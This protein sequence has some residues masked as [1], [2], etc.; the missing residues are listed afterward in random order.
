M[1]P[2]RN[3]AGIWLTAA[4]LIQ[5]AAFYAI[6]SR[7]EVTPRFAPLDA[8]PAAFGQWTLLR[9]NPVTSDVQAILRADDTMDRLYKNPAGEPADLF[10]AYFK[11]QRTGA[12]PHS[13]KNC[14]PGSGWEPVETP[15]K[16]SI[17]VSGRAAPIIVNR[18]TV[19]RGDQQA[20]VLY[21]YEGHDRVIASEFAAKF[22]LIVDAIRYR[23]SD[24]ALVK[25]VAPFSS[26][27]SGAALRTAVEFV[28]AIY[29]SIRVQLPL[30]DSSAGG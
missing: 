29:P 28:Q 27:D 12:S 21:W 25:V 7:R 23:R 5:G 3:R 17:A 13:P 19:A 16:I 9:E 22:W 20:V 2:I 10:I 18:Y 26:A 30:E 6:A 14:L 4:L 24:T 1:R 15:G 8:F 11:T